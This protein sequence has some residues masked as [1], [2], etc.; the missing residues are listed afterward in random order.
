LPGVQ[1][2]NTWAVIPLPNP[3]SFANL[4]A[5]GLDWLNPSGPAAP[6]M[7]IRVYPYLD[8]R[9]FWL[10]WNGTPNPTPGT[11]QTAS[12]FGNWHIQ[13]AEGAPP[14]GLADI[15]A[16]APITEIHLR[17]GFW[18]QPGHSIFADNVYIGFKDTGLTTFNFEVPE[19]STVVFL[20][21][22][23]GLWLAFHLF[24][25]RRLRG[26]SLSVPN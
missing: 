20:V 9:T 1:N 15:P 5:A 2:T 12:I 16:D 24:V 14:A 21:V 10:E 8:P 19:P 13:L 17:G 6:D 26:T 25:H 7:A 4:N 3:D 11:W 18:D 23:L 22:N